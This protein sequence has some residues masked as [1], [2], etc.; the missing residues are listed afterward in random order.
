MT[1]P[2]QPKHTKI[3]PIRRLSR[4]A[5]LLL[6]NTGILIFATIITTLIYFLASSPTAPIVTPTITPIGNPGHAPSQLDVSTTVPGHSFYAVPNFYYFPSCG[7]PC[8]LPLYKLPTEQSAFVTDGWPCEYYDPKSAS[9]G[10]YCIQ[11]PSGRTPTM[12]ANPSNK[13]SG[14][15]I[16]VICQITKLGGRAAQAI[17]NEAGQ[18]SN[19][20]DVVAVPA[21]HISR[22][23]IAVTQLSKAPGMPG[24][25]EAYGPD[26]WLGNTGWH[27]IPCK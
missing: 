3:I 12:M 16:L 6:V 20:W 18:S 15:R 11:P 25:Y 22:N 8:W 14:D 9:S 17:H 4:S 19:I 13:D 23:S 7:R 5:K 21:A 2:T 10:P 1:T 24:F 26:I 27:D